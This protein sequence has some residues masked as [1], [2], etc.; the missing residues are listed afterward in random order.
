MSASVQT[1]VPASDVANVK[2]VADALVTSDINAEKG[3]FTAARSIKKIVEANLTFDHWEAVRTAFIAEYRA[4]REKVTGV[5]IT[6]ETAANRWLAVAEA[7]RREFGVEKPKAATAEAQRKQNQRETQNAAKAAVTDKAKA[8]AAELGETPDPQALM[9]KAAEIVKADPVLGAAVTDLAVAAHK[10][11]TEAAIKAAKAAAKDLQ[12][13]VAKVAKATTDVTALRT[14]LDVMAA[15]PQQMTVI[16]AILAADDATLTRVARLLSVPGFDK[17]TSGKGKGKGK[18]AE[19]PA[20]DAGGKAA[21]A[22]A[23][24]LVKAG[25]SPR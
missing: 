2:P 8:I 10:A 18:G 9:A 12:D 21:A 11:A 13:K 17:A 5:A 4:F 23:D 19:H 1:L 7:M 3:L 25:V 24:A 6:E 20:H 14:A 15:G 16:A 22:M